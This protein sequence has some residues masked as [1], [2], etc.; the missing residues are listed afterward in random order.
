[1]KQ[2]V[3]GVHLER[4]DVEPVAEAIPNGDVWFSAVS[5]PDD[6]PMGDRELLLRVAKIRARLLDRATFIA[7][8]Y[9]FALSGAPASPPARWRTTLESNRQNVE[10]TLKVAS[11]TPKPRP[12]REDFSSGAAYLRA[13]HDSSAEV[14]QTF[15]AAAEKAINAI[16][17]RWLPRDNAS[18]EMAAL[19][20]RDR[21]GEV[22]AAGESLKREF[23]RVPFLL[24]G[25]WPL[26]VF[27][28]VD[29][30]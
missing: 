3:I 15:K 13:L 26:E 17:H 18:I 21:V 19:I 28:D 20:R 7:V 9:G 10:M 4:E 25:P 12:H 22:R 23:P 1:M 14:D 27:A 5:V 11:S 16:D 30:E 29:H 2:I 6:Q 24:S 8:R